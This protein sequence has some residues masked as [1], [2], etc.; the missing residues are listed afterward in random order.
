MTKRVQNPAFARPIAHRGLHDKAQG[1]IEN[2]KT[3]FKRALDAGFGIECDLQLTL[4][5][6]PVVIHDDTVDRVTGHT[7]LVRELSEKE[8]TALPLAGSTNPDTTLRFAELLQL[9]NGKS[10]LAVELKPQSADRNRVLV[11]RAV[12]QIKGYEGPFAFITFDPRLLSQLRE[13]GYRGHRGVIIERFTSELALRHLSSR[14]RF[15]MRHLLHYPKTRF[16]FV[17][18]DQNALSLPAVRL[19]RTLGFPVLTWTITSQAEA[20]RAAPHADQ[21]G[22]ENFLPRI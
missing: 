17:A 21:I 20:D 13:I 19:V 18:C 6:K 7:G 8:V 5:D 2:S 12:E 14:Q 1:I 11:E 9:V 3:A 10:P 16:D 22:F 15:V 4:D